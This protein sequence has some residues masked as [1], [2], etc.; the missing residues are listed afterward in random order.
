MINNILLIVAVFNIILSIII[1]ILSTVRK[2]KSDGSIYLERNH[3]GIYSGII[4]M[5]FSFSFLLLLLLGKISVEDY[6]D[7]AFWGIGGMFFVCGVVLLIGFININQVEMFSVS[8]LNTDNK[9]GTGDLKGRAGG[10][11]GM[12]DLKGQSGGINDLK[13]QAGGIGG[14]D[15]LKGRAGGIGGMDDLKGRAGGIGGM[16]DLKGRAGV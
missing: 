3:P 9:E 10:I 14:M 5:I 1:I 15:D 16:D 6:S 2:R 4:I 7:I 11:G 13:G 8:N 12:N